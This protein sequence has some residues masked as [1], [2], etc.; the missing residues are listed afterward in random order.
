MSFWFFGGDALFVLGGFLWGWLGSQNR[1]KIE[2]WDVRR[3]IPLFI[4]LGDLGI[5][6]EAIEHPDRSMRTMVRL[7]GQ[8][9]WAG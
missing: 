6:E 7:L 8:C 9:F 4:G 2:R 1:R 5:D 3:D